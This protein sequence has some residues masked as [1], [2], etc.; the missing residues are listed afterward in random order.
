MDNKES[1]LKEP[2]RFLAC[3]GGCLIYS[4]GVSL[5]VSPSGFYSGGF[6]GISQVLYTLLTR[7]TSLDFGSYNVTGIIYFLMNI[8]VLL[9]AFRQMNLLFFLKTILCVAC[10]TVFLS[11]IQVSEAVLAGDALGCA[12]IG[13][14]LG[15]LGIGI[16]LYNGGS[17]GGT[18]VIG[19]Y[20]T[21]KRS[22]MSVGR[23][24]M[25]VNCLIYAVCIILFDV[26]VAIY[27][28]IYA[29]FSGIVVDQVHAQN[30]NM[31][32]MI[33]TGTDGEE[34]EERVM[35]SLRRGITRWNGTGAYAESQKTILYVVLSKYEAETLKQIVDEVDPDAFVTFE[36]GVSIH[37]RY[38][39][40]L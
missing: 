19:V 6:V 39:K 3:I 17:A 14:I 18:D 5:F 2:M 7:F 12:I 4:C 30:I 38:A 31:Q 11:V 22:D 26:S 37:G 35:K 27:S 21:M 20:L 33:I 34:I 29:V 10:N 9:L 28:I 16:I 36:Q 40:H 15:G 8:P 23:L 32:A 25:T 13:G 1:R 24:S